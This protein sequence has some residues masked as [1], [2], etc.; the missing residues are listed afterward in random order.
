MGWKPPKM[1]EKGLEIILRMC[2]TDSMT[3]SV[4]FWVSLIQIDTT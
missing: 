3:V 2:Y 4:F 1:G